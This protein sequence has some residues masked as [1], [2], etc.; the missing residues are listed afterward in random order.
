MRFS[1]RFTV[2]LPIGAEIVIQ[3]AHDFLAPFVTVVHLDLL[4]LVANQFLN[5]NSALTGNSEHDAALFSERA[6]S[7]LR[8][9]DHEIVVLFGLLGPH[10]I[11]GSD[12]RLELLQVFICRHWVLQNILLEEG[13]INGFS[14]N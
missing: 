14:R 11:L 7:H 13:G 4:V 6:L 9:L 2:A 3:S 10:V 5:V 1:I 12:G 8:L